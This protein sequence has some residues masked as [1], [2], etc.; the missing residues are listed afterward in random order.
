MPRSSIVLAALL[1][2]FTTLTPS[3]RAASSTLAVTA[4]LPAD[5]LRPAEAKAVMAEVSRIWRPYGVEVDWTRSNPQA[6]TGA[7]LVVLV[8]VVER[9]DTPGV[10]VAMPL[11][12]VVRVNGRMRRVIYVSR[13]AIDE[14]IQPARRDLHA[15]M[16]ELVFGRLAGRVI[17]HELGHLLLDSAAHSTE[18]LMRA[19]FLRSDVMGGGRG[20]Y[21]LTPTERLRLDG[22]LA[23]GTLFVTSLAWNADDEEIQ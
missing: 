12:A 9:I 21:A 18:G 8:R 3:A 14:L 11:G 1:I 20:A 19:R 2:A 6:P 15:A 4:V 5:S 10:P 17:A 13:P 23:G 22:R 7:R 16:R